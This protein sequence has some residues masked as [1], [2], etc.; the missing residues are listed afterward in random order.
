[1]SCLDRPNEPVC[2]VNGIQGS[3]LQ[4]NLWTTGKEE[5]SLQKG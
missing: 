1:M 3:V 5:K 4:I 2:S